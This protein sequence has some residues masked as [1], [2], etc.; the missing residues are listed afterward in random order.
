MLAPPE[1][2]ARSPGM[3]PNGADETHVKD[4]KGSI[5]NTADV[6]GDIQDLYEGV[7]RPDSTTVVAA[8]EGGRQV[9]RDSLNIES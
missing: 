1:R 7:Q 8:Q 2:E 3:S 5:W 4:V 9:V 6:P